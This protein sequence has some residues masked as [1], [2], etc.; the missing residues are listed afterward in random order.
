VLAVDSLWPRTLPPDTLER[1]TQFADLTRI[2]IA[3]V[4]ARS[5][6][7]ASRARLVAAG[8][9]ERR[10]VVRDL[11]D[12]AQ[13]AL[14]QTILSLKMAQQGLASGDPEAPTRV[15]Q[16]LRQAERATTELRELS[17]GILPAVLTHAGLSAAL[18]TLASRSVVPVTV[19]AQVGRLPAAVEASAYFVVAEGLTNIAK[20]AHASQATVSV[21]VD[22][23][24]L[25]VEVRDDGAGGAHA[26]GS[27]LLGLGD[28]LAALSGRLSVLS[29]PGEGTTLTAIIPL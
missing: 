2:A 7:A 25:R 22:D 18:A 5:E 8:D 3:N 12:G 19:D 26:Q 16:A 27:G 29:P 28:R 13:Q 10:R 15:D 11:H 21:R 24:K 4:A 1:L 20:H 6:A 23:R 17:H 14:V 9:V